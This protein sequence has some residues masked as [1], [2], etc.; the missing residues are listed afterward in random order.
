MRPQDH[1]SDHSI[2]E[3]KPVRGIIGTWK[4]RGLEAP[5]P[6]AP[7]VSRVLAS[8][9]IGSGADATKFLEPK[10]ADLHD[11]SLL[12]GLERSAER[13]LHAI[14]T[15]QRIVIYGDYDVDGITASAI[16]YHVILEVAKER[17]IEAHVSTYVP[18]RLEEGYGLNVDAIEEIALAGANLIISV[19]C[20]VTAF[21]P[22][23]AARRAGVDLIITD[24]HN[25]PTDAEGL[26]DAFAVVHPR[27][28]GSNYPFG[29]LCGAGVAFKLAWRLATM[30]A[31]GP[32]VSPG[33][34]RVLLD[35]LA[36]ASLGVIAD[37][38]PLVDE[39]R[40]L[41][42]HGLAM[43]RHSGIEGV[44]ALVVASGLA[45]ENIGEYD[46]GFKLA[47]RLNA[48]GR[49]GHA[50][51]AVELFTTATGD[52]AA[53]IAAQLTQQNDERRRTQDEILQQALELAESSGMT[54]DARRAI[55]LAKEGWHAGVVGIVCSK[56]VERYHRP[57]L[58]MSMHD[59]HCHGS[60]RSIDG[61]DLHEA[62]GACSTHLIGFGGH[63]MAAGLR[64]SADNLP[65][66]TDA[67]CAFA[68]T[69]LRAEDLCARVRFDCDATIADLTMAAVADLQ[70]LAPF[71]RENPSVQLRL[72]SVV[73]AQRPEAMGAGNKHMTLRVAD[74][75]GERQLRLV[76]WNWGERITR[77]APG[78]RLQA[79]IA[80]KVS[81]WNGS[82]RVE[83]ELIDAAP[84]ND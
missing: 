55:V 48:C 2:S 17:G 12:P 14:A 4:R 35:T 6:R 74:G 42:R 53:E 30:A 61:F 10:I 21:E 13:V 36:L 7:L 84:A 79:V 54:G 64:M 57:V 45:G 11:P 31:G 47:P 82:T 81:T 8:R 40:V 32:K 50:R 46:V 15:G 25:L 23:R 70:K 77:F 59:G 71:G 80:P 68:S 75:P 28:P 78:M 20:G 69:K 67:F 43:V 41:A 63:A 29:E 83:A 22:A 33:M 37:I 73:V 62:I 56:L 51:E 52:R 38:V 27:L 65:A 5:D 16:L 34:R 26:P 18:H 19:D 3:P 44:R 66:F 39:N 58:L 60:G 72:P 49:M 9:G 24:H 76:A 1:N